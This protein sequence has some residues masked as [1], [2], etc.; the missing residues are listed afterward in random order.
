[1]KNSRWPSSLR[2]AG[3]HLLFSLMV[4]AVAAAVVFLVWYPAPYEKISG[5]FHLFLLLI[6]VDVVMGPLLTFVVFDLRK[7]RG[8]LRRD[9][10]VIV[11]L[12]LS[13]LIYGVATMAQARPVYL[14]FEGDR[15]RV[16]AWVDV[17]RS[18]MQKAPEELQS[19]SWHG[20]VPLGVRLA[21][22]SDRD[23][24]ESIRLALE[25][26]HPSFRPSRWIPY[27]SQRDGVSGAAL[28]MSSLLRRYP[29]SRDQVLALAQRENLSVEGMGFLPLISG[30]ESNWV[31]VVRLDSAS[32]VGYLPFDGW[33]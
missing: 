8:E 28:P 15:F 26:L 12:Q 17:D 3:F 4:A 20:P 19:L 7:P 18:E 23:F 25:G 31:V 27:G 30:T 13:A 21:T 6:S 29:S 22:G 10:G 24:P 1:M 14:A 5:G 2:A 11:I 16:V 32:V 33:I 9:L